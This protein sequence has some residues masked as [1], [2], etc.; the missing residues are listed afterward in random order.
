[1]QHFSLLAMFCC[2]SLSWGAFFF[3]AD[4]RFC[5]FP[6]FSLWKITFGKVAPAYAC[7]FF[8]AIFSLGKLRFPRIKLHKKSKT[9]TGFYFSEKI[10]AEREGFEPPDPCGSTVFKTAAIDHSATSPRGFPISFIGLQIRLSHCFPSS[11][12]LSSYCGR[13]FYGPGGD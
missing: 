12:R 13:F 1:M 8:Y 3:C 7:Y 4:C 11:L 5:G 9:P 6:L 10:Y 2:C